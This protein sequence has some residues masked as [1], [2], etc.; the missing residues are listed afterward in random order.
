[1]AH[2]H[3]ML[4]TKG[5]KQMLRICNTYC[6]SIATVAV[7]NRTIINV[8][9][10]LAVLCVIIESFRFYKLVLSLGQNVM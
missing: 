3:C 6:F 4:D 1:M 7:R 5:Y 8:V 10:T 9:C 2:A